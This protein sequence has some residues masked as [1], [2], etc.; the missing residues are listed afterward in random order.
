MFNIKVFVQT[1]RF[2]A[3][4]ATPLVLVNSFIF[5]FGSVNFLEVWLTRFCLN[6]AV[7]FPQ[8]IIYVS[9]VKWFDGREKT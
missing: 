2:V 7:T 6:F 8:A 3:L 5:S 9:L 1:L 4:I